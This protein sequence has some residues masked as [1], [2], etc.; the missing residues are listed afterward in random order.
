[1]PIMTE[2]NLTCEQLGDRVNYYKD[3]RGLLPVKEALQETFEVTDINLL[4]VKLVCYERGFIL[5]DQRLGTFVLPYADLTHMVFHTENELW[6]EIG[7]R[8]DKLH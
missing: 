2:K 4:Q 5:V 3:L 7:L 6:L 1:M 8:Q